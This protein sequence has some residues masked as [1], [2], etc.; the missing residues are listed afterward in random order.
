MVE[1]FQANAAASQGPE[2]ALQASQGRMTALGG[3]PTSGPNE[4]LK[5]VLT[6]VFT[7]AVAGAMP[8]PAALVVT[9]QVISMKLIVRYLWVPI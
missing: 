9:G 1:K 7:A 8:L 6:G 3:N 2:S 4:L 5:G